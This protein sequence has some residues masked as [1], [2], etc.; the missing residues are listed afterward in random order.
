MSAKAINEATGKDL[1]NRVLSGQV[2]IK[3]RFA[4]V[5]K[6]TCWDTLLQEHPWLKTEVQ[7]D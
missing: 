5:N 2:A 3:C 6:E 4:T 1:L 7:N